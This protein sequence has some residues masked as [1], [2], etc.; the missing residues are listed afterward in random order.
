MRTA[1]VGQRLLVWEHA[2]TTGIHCSEIFLGAGA[3]QSKFVYFSTDPVSVTGVWA[4][5][6]AHLSGIICLEAGFGSGIPRITQA[7]IMHK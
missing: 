7:T 4:S 3:Y 6:G 2:Q 5:V 1:I